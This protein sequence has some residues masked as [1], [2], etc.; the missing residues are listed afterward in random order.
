MDKKLK[1]TE[2]MIESFSWQ[3]TILAILQSEKECEDWIYSNY[4][5]IYSVRKLFYNYN[6]FTAEISFFYNLDGSWCFY[7]CKT[8]PWLD[9]FKIHRNDILTKWDS[10]IDFVLERITMNEYV[11]VPINR[12]YIS[13]YRGKMNSH[14]ML[15]YG[16]N[17]EKQE[18]Y[19]AD[20][21]D[22]K[23]VFETVSFNELQ[24]GFEKLDIHKLEPEITNNYTDIYDVCTFKKITPIWNKTAYQFHLSKLIN[25]IKEYLLFDGFGMA[26][27]SNEKYVFGIECYSALATYIHDAFEN[28]EDSY[29]SRPFYSFLDHKTIMMGRILYL[30]RKGYIRDAKKY[31]DTYQRISD[32][33][34]III[35]KIVKINILN[36]V[37]DKIISDICD[38]INKAKQE[39]VKI[40]Y[41]MIGEL[42]LAANNIYKDLHC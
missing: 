1:I 31:L 40:L 37:S 26:Y 23:F 8:N 4:M 35:N 17:T 3:S 11:Y 27:R 14:T 9:Y 30:K 18:F 25:D 10:V 5:Q 16:F 7:E 39:E 28:Q 41:E 34:K 2:P 12:Q 38:N 19:C 24:N 32:G 42:E 13:A 29:D 20:N 15:I 22:G 36:H 6:H 21:F 33:V